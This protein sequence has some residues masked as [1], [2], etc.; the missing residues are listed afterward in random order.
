MTL[1]LLT[2]AARAKHLAM[3]GVLHTTPEDDLGDGTLVLFGPGEPGFWAHVTASPEFDGGAPDPVDRWSR[4]VVSKLASEFD[5][6]ALFPFGDPPRPFIAWALR[7]GHAFVSP[8][9]LL[10]HGEVGLFVSFRGAILLPERLDLPRPP[11][12]PCESCHDKPCLTACPPKALIRSGYDLD[13]CHDYLDTP[14]GQ[15]CMSKGCAVRRAC[16]LAANYSRL[17]THSAY[18]MKAFHP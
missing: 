17:E 11:E 1:A 10:V 8:A 3:F 5:G 7:S 18:H 14:Q 9:S 6:T 13:A 4:R 2:K 16:P 15:S 12:N